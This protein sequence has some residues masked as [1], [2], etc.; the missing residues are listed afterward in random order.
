MRSAGRRSASETLR[1]AQTVQRA[2]D[3]LSVFDVEQPSLS[4]AEISQAVS[5]TLPTTHRLLKALQSKEMVV[6]DRHSRRYSLGPQIIRLAGI[7]LQRD[8]LISL[9][10]PWLQ[11]LRA[12]SGETASLHWR[13]GEKR[14]CVREF[15]SPQPIR[16]VS[17]V[18][19]LYPLV[20]GAAGKAILAWL[21]P[22]TVDGIFRAEGLVGRK[23]AA[24]LE[25][26]DAVRRRGYATSTGETTHGASAIA[27]PIMAGGDDA[28]ASLNVTGPELRFTPRKAAAVQGLLLE[29]C[30]EVMKQLGRS[31]APDAR[32]G[33]HS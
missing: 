10:E 13:I 28:V 17:G 31:R 11:K 26:L 3:I 8:D 5:L 22:E 29:A 14:M 1:G 15:V 18:G 19:K 30:G 12:A 24:L 6:W 7:I 33:N 32:R 16:M 23:R 9:V 20:R 2:L 27:A 21:S 25:D 4:T